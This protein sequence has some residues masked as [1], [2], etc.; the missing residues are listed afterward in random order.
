M[1]EGWMGLDIG[2]KSLELFQKELT[3]CK[4][5]I[6]N[7]PMGVFE[8]PKC[9]QPHSLTHRTNLVPSLRWAARL[10]TSAAIDLGSSLL[11][12]PGLRRA[13]WA[14]PRCLPT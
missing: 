2:P 5:I 14:S 13:R 11:A 12:S 7:G 9:V 8:M 1:P 4:T 10:I 3:E 6:W